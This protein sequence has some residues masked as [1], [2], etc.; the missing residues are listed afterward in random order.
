LRTISTAINVAVA[1]IAAVGEEA[2]DER[3]EYWR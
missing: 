1:G 3:E 2:L